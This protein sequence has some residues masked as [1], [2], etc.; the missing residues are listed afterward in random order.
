MERAI[1]E[2]AAGLPLIWLVVYPCKPEWHLLSAV[3]FR[4]GAKSRR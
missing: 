4:A 3:S 1:I 2:R